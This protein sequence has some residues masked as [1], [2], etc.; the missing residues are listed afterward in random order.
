VD[1]DSYWKGIMN[2]FKVKL[3]RFCAE[4]RKLQSVNDNVRALTKCDG[5]LTTTDEEA[6]CALVEYF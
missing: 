5:H 4:M 2:G 1:E 6:A 3:K